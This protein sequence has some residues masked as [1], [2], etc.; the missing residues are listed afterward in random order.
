MDKGCNVS[1]PVH[2]LSALIFSRSK[3]KIRLCLH[4]FLCVRSA[5]KLTHGSA[6]V[7]GRSADLC[8]GKPL[9]I[10]YNNVKHDFPPLAILC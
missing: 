1:Y 10:L 9:F 4:V 6:A 8:A 5:M 7:Q 3:G 2:D